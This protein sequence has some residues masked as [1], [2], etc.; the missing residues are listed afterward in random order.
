[1]E[2][3]YDAVLVD[4]SVLVGAS[5]PTDDVHN[6]CGPLFEYF[7]KKPV[8]IV[9]DSIKEN[10]KKIVSQK[11]GSDRVNLQL[12]EM[13]MDLLKTEEID[14]RELENKILSAQQFYF[15]L[16]T[17]VRKHIRQSKK[18][19]TMQINTLMKNVPKDYRES[20]RERI[21]EQVSRRF[22]ASIERVENI[23][24]EKISDNTPCI[25]NS[26][27][28]AE[29]SQL[30]SK[31]PSI[32]VAS[33]DFHMSPIRLAGGIVEPFI[34]NLIDDEFGIFCEWPHIIS[35]K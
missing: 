28:L 29:A 12:L 5:C 15:F 13:N 30:K 27:V 14:Y 26:I 2:K 24:S 20:V 21:E 25:S 11:Y 32:A 23:L 19:A 18:E 22:P 10:A 7:H 35:K 8:G 33:T 4:V 17:S 31:Y 1:M 3:V 34:P 16:P 6:R 9:T